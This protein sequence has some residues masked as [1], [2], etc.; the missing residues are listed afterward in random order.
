MTAPT[1]A[2]AA[3]KLGGG[4]VYDWLIGSRS[5]GWRRRGRAELGGASGT[6]RGWRSTDAA[7]RRL[8]RQGQIQ[9]PARPASHQ[10]RGI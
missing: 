1:P 4:V 9:T 6:G 2:A 3:G 10:T 5:A 8:R 7:W